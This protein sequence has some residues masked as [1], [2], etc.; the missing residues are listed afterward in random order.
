MQK[1]NATDGLAAVICH[2]HGLLAKVVVGAE[3]LCRGCGRWYRARPGDE[4]Q[5]LELR[6][7]RNQRYYRGRQ[8]SAIQTNPQAS[9]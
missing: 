1:Q 7:A 4:Q 3:V 2:K 5:K 6:R 8:A 9:Q